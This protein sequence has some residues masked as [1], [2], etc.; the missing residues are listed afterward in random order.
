MS[1]DPINWL[2]S[3][4]REAMKES[5]ERGFSAWVMPFD[6]GWVG[7]EKMFEIVKRFATNVTRPKQIV[8]VGG[9]LCRQR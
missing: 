2:L 9:P 3:C 7:D 8:F 4:I 5:C 1:G 6:V